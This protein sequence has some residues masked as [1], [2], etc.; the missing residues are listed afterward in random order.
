MHVAH[1]DGEA[2]FWLAPTI[3]LAVNRGLSPTQLRQALA[4]ITA[5]RWEIEDAWTTYFGR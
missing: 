5:N 2:K 1:P 4:I 3:E